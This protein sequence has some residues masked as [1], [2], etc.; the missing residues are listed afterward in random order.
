GG[1][2]GS[3]GAVGFTLGALLGAFL[4]LLA[5]LAL[6]RVVRG[7]PLHQAFGG[8]QAR[9]AVGRLGALLQPVLD[10]LDLQDRAVRI[11]LL[12]QRVEGAHLLDEAAVARRMAV[13]DDDR[14]VRAPLGAAAGETSLQRR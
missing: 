3:G 10:A 2:R 1:F 4:G 13:G 12:Q 14:V 6:L 9:D 11:V 7:F 5:G 8:E